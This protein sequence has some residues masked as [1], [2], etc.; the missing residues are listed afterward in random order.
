MSAA[1]FEQDTSAGPQEWEVDPKYEFN[2]PKFID[3]TKVDTAEDSKADEWFEK[4]I[5]AE[6]DYLDIDSEDED[7]DEDMLSEIASVEASPFQMK[8]PPG[9][10]SE[11][12]TP[13]LNS[14]SKFRPQITSVTKEYDSVS[15]D[16]SSIS[17]KPVS[18]ITKV[19]PTKK[20][21]VQ[22]VISNKRY[23]ATAAK[24]Q[25]TQKK[26]VQPPKPIVK[27]TKPVVKQPV[28]PPKPK[29]LTAPI[30]APRVANL[31]SK[32]KVQTIVKAPPPVSIKEKL[33]QM[34]MAKNTKTNNMQ[35][36]YKA[37]IGVGRFQQRVEEAKKKVIPPAKSY[38]STYN[39]QELHK[40]RPLSKISAEINTTVAP[41]RTRQLQNQAN[42]QNNVRHTTK[43]E[44]KAVAKTAVQRARAQQAAASVN[45]IPEKSKRALTVPVTPEFLRR[46]QQKMMKKQVSVM[47]TEEREMYEAQKKREEFSKM[48]RQK[49]IALG[50]L[51]QINNNDGGENDESVE[52]QMELMQRQEV[53]ERK[54]LLYQLNYF[55]RP[56]SM[57]TK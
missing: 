37:N 35:P 46:A 31:A 19:N 18:T 15:E 51:Y 50:L 23:A 8:T 43:P 44:T 57:V 7:D 30:H 2:A 13:T 6:K 1:D 55:G 32:T 42:I 27:E 9:Y 25:Q 24:T 47:T 12:S 41:S 38:T 5:R 17:E 10:F 14:A 48:Q 22:T 33:L 34:Q 3:F 4:Q 39:A 29:P 54:A 40:R 52:R 21:T 28:A 49:L 16:E 11:V 20:A 36:R 56:K 26:V 53:E 45:F